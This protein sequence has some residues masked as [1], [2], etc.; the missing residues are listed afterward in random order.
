MG[1][2]RI[3][4]ESMTSNLAV[5][6]NDPSVKYDLYREQANN[7]DVQT[8]AVR[9]R[10]A[11]YTQADDVQERLGAYKAGMVQT[12]YGIDITVWRGYKRDPA[13]KAELILADYYDKVLDWV[14]QCQPSIITGLKLL[15]FG[16]DG[17]SDITRL[18]RT[19]T[20]TLRFIGQRDLTQTQG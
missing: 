5:F 8:L 14:R 6:V 15:Y 7:L 20:Q 12:R 3:I 19:V 16:Y 13:D 1:N 2:S 17:S 4:L 11:M 18:E 9:C 10:I